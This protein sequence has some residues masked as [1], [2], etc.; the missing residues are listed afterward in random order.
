[1]SVPQKYKAFSVLQFTSTI[2]FL[3]LSYYTHQAPICLLSPL[4]FT[5][6]KSLLTLNGTGNLS[7]LGNALEVHI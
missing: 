1:M 6:S 4:P 5:L 7:Y 3:K 2:S